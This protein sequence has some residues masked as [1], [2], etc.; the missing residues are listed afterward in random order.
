MFEF[1]LL[2]NLNN[3]IQIQKHQ[4]VIKIKIS[5]LCGQP[6]IFI[7]TVS[8]NKEIS[9]NISVYFFVN[10]CDHINVENS[11][12]QMN[13]DIPLSND[14]YKVKMSKVLNINK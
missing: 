1:R 12:C 7:R 5:Y 4:N 13:V 3:Q 8:L 10:Y 14:F 11:R 2:T 6:I 9:S